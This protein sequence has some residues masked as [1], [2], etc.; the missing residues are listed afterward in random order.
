MSKPANKLANKTITCSKCE[1]TK[2][3]T[4]NYY[5]YGGEFQE[6][7]KYGF[8]PICKSCLEEGFLK[9]NPTEKEE[10][11][12]YIHMTCQTI[13]KPF[14]N[15]LFENSYKNG[16]NVFRDYFGKVA[17]AKYNTKS[18]SDGDDIRVTMFGDIDR[19]LTTEEINRWDMYSLE[20]NFKIIQHESI[21]QSIKKENSIPET[22]DNVNNICN[23]VILKMRLANET[24]KGDVGTI[25][26]LQEAVKAAENSLGITK[27]INEIA[28]GAESFGSLIAML[29]SDDPYFEKDHKLEDID[30]LLVT[31][32]KVLGSTSVAFGRT[33]KKKFR[34]E[35]Y[36]KFEVE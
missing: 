1:K 14:F 10:I 25:K 27:A 23:L 7:S 15:T 28:G 26:K 2:A 21:Y 8:Y 6:F 17:N 24:A 13:N 3:I 9:F 30:G 11:K 19:D 16:G 4:R 29:E 31:A 32:K 33:D 36:K 18:F 35:Y 5:K 34:E 20:N 22:V 12:K